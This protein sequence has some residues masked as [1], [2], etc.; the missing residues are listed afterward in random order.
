M[1]K[2]RERRVLDAIRF[3]N[4]LIK[5]PKE[6]LVRK[7]FETG[8]QRNKNNW[9][10]HLKYWLEFLDMSDVWA[11]GKEIDIDLVKAR[12][13]DRRKTEWKKEVESKP[14]LRTYTLSKKDIE[15]EN[16]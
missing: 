5:L 4:S 6:R 13:W 2:G 8:K 12:L 15:T 10:M 1:L 3:Y 7:T 16:M 14:K 9:L 11:D